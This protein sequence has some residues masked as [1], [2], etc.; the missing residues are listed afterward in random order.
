MRVLW[1]VATLERYLAYDCIPKGL[2]VQKALSGDIGDPNT[3]VEWDSMFKEFS[4]RAVSFIIEKRRKQL[5]ESKQKIA[6]LFD[7]I[8]PY[9]NHPEIIR[10]STNISNRIKNKE[11]EIV[12]R[13]KSKFGRDAI[14]ECAFKGI[15][16]NEHIFETLD[17]TG[18]NVS[19]SLI[20]DNQFSIHPTPPSS[21]VYTPDPP[22]G[23]NRRS[24]INIEINSIHSN[25]DI[26]SSSTPLASHNR[27][28][29][30]EPN[31]EEDVN[32]SN[33]DKSSAITTEK[34]QT[35]TKHT[36]SQAPLRNMPTYSIYKLAMADF[37]TI[38]IHHLDV[39]F[40]NFLQTFLKVLLNLKYLSLFGKRV[41]SMFG[42]LLED[43]QIN[44][45]FI[46]NQRLHSNVV[47]NISPKIID[48]LNLP[49][50][51]INDSL[52]QWKTI[53]NEKP[54]SQCTKSCLPGSRKVPGNSIYFCCY[55]CIPCSEGEISNT[56]DNENCRKCPDHEWSNENKTQCVPKL[57]E[58]LSYS[59]DGIPVIALSGSILLL[60]VTAVILGI[61]IRY[62]HTPIVRANNKNLS[63]ILLISIML[64]FLCVFLFLGRPVDST[65]MLRQICTGLLLSVSIS[66]L[67][68]KTI[69]VYIAFKAT[70][71]GSVWRTWTGVKLPNC[72]LL[73]CTSVQVVICMSWLTL[74]PPFQ[75]LDTHS[76]TEKIIVQCNE[77]SDLWFYSVLGYMG[78]LAAPRTLPDSFN[79][80]KYITFSMLVFCSVWIAMIPAYL[81]TRGKYTVAWRYLPS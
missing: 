22:T 35:K 48:N 19:T 34:K 75:D 3:L 28:N 29:A 27:F 26:N 71:P 66:S 43:Y 11:K 41:F 50:F 54:K 81:S 42:D 77:G 49:V 24:S 15:S 30:L 18:G 73:I 32:N 76:Y 65:C 36:N 47:G 44:N 58:F 40:L 1:E 14:P 60:T 33:H 55:G 69:M 5:M 59:D 8:K 9:K 56:S 79:E 78:I 37:V 80:A 38:A 64:S 63:F 17:E 25:S 53:N 23:I 51:F 70:K 52:I 72:V 2:I 45:H 74:C 62:Q 61:F 16:Q 13:K 20:S 4:K 10:I 31:Q 6:A 39:P 46:V 67:L 7:I 68:A 21:T 12:E 57:V